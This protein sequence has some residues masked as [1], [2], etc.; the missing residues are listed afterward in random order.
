ME[1]NKMI[2]PLHNYDMRQVWESI[3]EQ[4]EKV[5]EDIDFA[6]SV[7]PVSPKDLLHKV[8]MQIFEMSHE[9]QRRELSQ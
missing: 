8:R 7:D 1:R 9:V 4:L 3:S 5:E 6:L 2:Q